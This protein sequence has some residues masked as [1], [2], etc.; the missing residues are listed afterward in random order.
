MKYLLTLLLSLLLAAPAQA[1]L[2][3]LE[4]LLKDNPDLQ[5]IAADP[6]HQVQI[7]YTRIDR[8]ADNRP[9]FTTYAYGEDTSRYFYP[10]ST[11]KMPAAFLALERLRQLGLDQEDVM[12]TGASHP[13]Q[14]PAVG[15]T[16]AADGLP[17]VAHYIKKI[18]LVSDNDAYNRLYE[19][20][21]Q[22]YF[23]Q[24]LWDKGYDRV[25]ILHRLSAPAYD[26]VTNRYTNP[27]TFLRDDVLRY[28]QGEVYS[29]ADPELGLEGQVRGRG[30]IDGEGE[31]VEEPFDFR[32]KN[33]VGL[34][35]L[36]DM[37]QAVLF[38]EAVPAE[39]RFD[40]SEADYRFLYRYMSML[41]RESDYPAYPEDPYYDGY[42]K[43]FLF[44]DNKERIPENIRVFNKVG[45]AYG[46]LT[47]VA[48]VV[49]FENGVE[50]M[51]AANIH[52][53]D[54]QVFND[55]VYE[56]DDIGFPFLAE[57][58]RVIYKHEL[59]RERERRPDLERFRSSLRSRY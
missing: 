32:Y 42:V 55:G 43:F 11:V 26:A 8:D 2:D 58:G 25:R 9:H 22:A 21:G 50:F 13:P 53:N 16:S 5:R 6:A 19:F 39:R 24:A 46:F 49:D 15:D 1:Q 30:Y 38:P 23:N 18:F 33:Y 27:V 52:V 10:A 44:G 20:L 48:Y 34:R 36:H 37:L 47:D 59:E 12:L 45:D 57:L 35:E 17:S 41:P 31:L 54:N 56:Y 14:T 28:H 3:P 4:Q 7:L 40:L 51:L 29:Q